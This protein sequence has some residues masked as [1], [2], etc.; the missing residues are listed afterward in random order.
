MAQSHKLQTGGGG[1]MAPNFTTETAVSS[2]F[3]TLS[4]CLENLISDL[5]IGYI[6]KVTPP[7]V[8]LPYSCYV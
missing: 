5:N 4:H 8:Y 1:E 6:S 7:E 2:L 3:V